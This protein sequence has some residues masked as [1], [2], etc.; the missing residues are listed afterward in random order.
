LW[1]AVATLFGLLALGAALV[2]VVV[3]RPLGV[4]LP[5]TVLLWLFG[6]AT[7]IALSDLLDQRPAD[8]KISWIGEAVHFVSASAVALV[9]AMIAGA[10]V[11]SLLGL[12]DSPAFG[13]AFGCDLVVGLLAGGLTLALTALSGVVGGKLSSWLLARSHASEEHANGVRLR[14]REVTTWRDAI[15]LLVMPVGGVMVSGVVEQVISSA[16]AQTTTVGADT[17]P[18]NPSTVG[19]LVVPLAVWAVTT[20]AVWFVFALTDRRPTNPH[21]P[22]VVPDITRVHRRRHRATHASALAIAVS[23]VVGFAFAGFLDNM[24]H[25][26]LANPSR[27]VPRVPIPLMPASA[28][29]AFLARAFVPRFELAGAEKWDP[30]TVTWYV[31]SSERVTAQS[32]GGHP[33]CARSGRETDGCRILCAKKAGVACAPPCDPPD[34]ACAPRGG[35]PHAV[36]YIY[37][38][39]ANTPRDGPTP[40]LPGWAVIEY[41]VFYNYDSLHAGLITQ[42]HE[43]DWEQVSV[44]VQQRR[45]TVHPIEVAFSEHCYGAVV[46]ASEVLWNGSHPTSFVGLGSHANY[47]TRNDLPIRQLQCLTRRTPRYLGAAGLF[48]N[49]LVAGWSIE[50][51]IAY[52]IGLR[53]QTDQPRLV[54]DAQPISQASTPDIASFH[55]YWGVDNNLQVVTGGVPTGAGPTSPQDQGPSTAPFYRMFC[56]SSW[57][58]AAHTAPVCPR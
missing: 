51:P 19:S 15:R 56:S 6:I 46:P 45:A 16:P 13:S 39:A 52:L 7:L 44:L 8:R 24:I 25:D 43:S 11:P 17:H 20:G 47:P 30:T 36:Y 49:P 12:S 22:Q 31:S 42:W 37:H 2:L 14:F 48:F 21:K 33:F 3:V 54:S 57:L 29:M 32:P 50:L 5:V 55:G 38:D 23:V 28:Q 40:P 58:K 4:R 53:D 9:F 34:G 10:F 41:W 1:A 35:Q 26:R 18:A 27:P